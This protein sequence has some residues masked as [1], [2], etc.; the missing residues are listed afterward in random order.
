M[1]NVI[2]SLLL[3]FNSAIISYE[4]ETKVEKIVYQPNFYVN[5][6][7]NLEIFVS[8]F[9]KDI[10]ELKVYFYDVENNLISNDFFSSS[11]IIE[12][13]KKTVAKIPF[14]FNK[15]IYLNIII[16]SDNS[17]KEIENILFP[18]YEKGNV[19]CEL[20]ESKQCVTSH[21]S[22]VIY[23]ESKI[24][25]KYEELYLITDPDIYSKNNILPI[26]KIN[27]LYNFEILENEANLLIYDEIEEFDLIYDEK[28]FFPLDIVQNRNVLSFNLLNSYYLD[29][30]DG[31]MYERY[32]KDT[33]CTDEIILPYK[34]KT[35]D[36]DIVI[37]EGFINFSKVIINFN[38]TTKGNLIGQ[39]DGCKYQIR[40][41]YL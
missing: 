29:I 26:N 16:Y 12:G 36:L 24:M 14:K 6:I 1:L 27:L 18:I 8:S 15:Q 30:V 41:N 38:V 35:Y 28:Y 25:E 20:T 32:V 10:V 3:F 33:I 34:N 17:K 40:R 21:P 19:I 39:C 23:E 13:K 5:G 7:I 31:K 37:N 2:L 11:I 22:L 4:N 9:V